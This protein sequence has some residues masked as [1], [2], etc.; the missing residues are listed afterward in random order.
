[1]PKRSKKKIDLDRENLKELIKTMDSVDDIMLWKNH[2]YKTDNELFT[3]E[4][5]N[6]EVTKVL[7]WE[8]TDVLYSF[9]GIYVIGLAAYYPDEFDRDG[10]IIKDSKS[11]NIYNLTRVN[12]IIE[13]KQKEYEENK[14][15][16][17]AFLDF[18]PQLINFIKRYFSI[19]NVIPTWPGANVDRGCSYMYDI[20]ELYY[21]KYEVWTKI[22]MEIYRNAYL[23]DILS[24]RL[25]F[26]N[27]QE[28]TYDPP[29]WDFSSTED[30]LD[31]I[32]N[33]QYSKIV[34]IY[35]YSKWLERIVGIIEKR[36]RL[37]KE[38]LKK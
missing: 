15:S 19:G 33:N 5:Y 28:I 6:K 4:E 7:G 32:V 3:V 17:S 11:R 10:V 18:N 35:L 27:N 13:S 38:E 14:L 1:M 22:L 26:E 31:N 2:P 37:L 12:K 9:L 8:K 36:E 25:V 23:E 30:F 24:D 34:R 21:S 29:F 16:K 20:P